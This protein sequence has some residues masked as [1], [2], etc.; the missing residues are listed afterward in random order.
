MKLTAVSVLLALIF[1]ASG[2]AKLASLQFELDAFARWGY[3]LWFMY[4]TGAI[5]VAGGLALLW[6]PL[7]ALAA[8]GLGAMMIGA[9][10]T[11]AVH[12]EWP[13]LV[14]ASAILLL[15]FWRGWAGRADIAALWRRVRP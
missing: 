13:M 2:G 6:R 4:A 9:V 7:S 12:A 15:A 3:P 14:L 8:A 1:L 10:A 11:H 5:E